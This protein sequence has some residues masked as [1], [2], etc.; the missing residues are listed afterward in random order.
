M[1]N[2]QGIPSTG[3][4]AA[5]SILTRAVKEDGFPAA[6]IEVGTP[7]RTLWRQAFGRL[8]TAPD[9][10]ATFPDTIFDLASLTKVLATTTFTMQQVEQG[11]IGLDDHIEAHIGA[12]L[13]TDRQ[14]V[15]IRDLLAHSSGLAAYIP[16]YQGYEP[17]SSPPSGIYKP[18][19]TPEGKP[20]TPDQMRDQ[21]EATI[22]RIP[23]DYVPRTQS[24][25]SDLGFI[26]LGF[27]L[28]KKAGLPELLDAM[29]V[30][31]KSTEDLQ[32]NPPTKWIP[33]TAP[34]EFDAWRNRALIGEVHDENA[35]ALRGAAGHAGLFGTAAACGE[36]ARHLLQV[37]GGNGGLIDRATA[38]TFITRIP[39]VPESSRALGW[40]TMLP[41]S[42]CGRRMSQR[43]FGHTGFT[44]TSLWVDPER[45][46]YVA[47]LTNRVNP[48]RANDTIRK[49]RPEVHDA[50]MDAPG[51]T[52]SLCE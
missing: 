32:F 45:A 11:L 30:Q 12:W 50:V 19:I 25:Y 22:C 39:D 34:T 14:H 26:L 17:V 52:E 29:R 42:S 10:P 44:G 36:Y 20:F 48:T 49:I 40:D 35:A 4:D 46:L 28:E 16:L 2:P 43:A 33:R 31:M 9:A 1:S 38:E 27:I 15:T 18:T 47:L 7:T 3:F 24:I 13:G 37:L 5:A 23:L 8:H 21:F 51:A 6:V 41:T